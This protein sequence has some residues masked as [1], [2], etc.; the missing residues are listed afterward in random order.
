MADGSEVTG[1]PVKLDCKPSNETIVE[2]SG[3]GG[4]E[5]TG[6]NAAAT[7][8]ERD[9]EL[10]ISDELM[11]KGDEAAA[12]KD[13][14]EATDCYSRALEIRATLFGEL[15]PR[16]VNAYYKYGC[17]LLRKAQEEAD[18]LVSVP[19]RKGDSLLNSC[20]DEPAKRVVSAES[21]AA[22]VESSNGEGEASVHNEKEINN[23]SK[24]KDIEENEEE[25]ESEDE[26]TSEGDEDESDL[27]LAW[28]ML[29]I[30]RAIV[31]KCSEDTM[32]KVDILTAL[33]EVA[34]EREDMETSCSDYLKALSILERLVEPDSR[35]VCELNFM[36][37]LCLETGSK[38][39]EAISYCE[40]AISVCKSRLERLAEEVKTSL[41]PTESSS[42]LS[43]TKSSTIPHSTD[44][45]DKEIE[46]LTD[47]CSELEKKRE[48]L[49]HAVANP[50]PVLQDILAMY[51]AKTKGSDKIS[52]SVAMDPSQVATV[53]SGG[54]LDS[55]TVSTAHT[56]GSSR[57]TDLGVVGRGVKRVHLDSIASETKPE[58]KPS[59]DP[60]N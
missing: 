36:I 59:L 24:L 7:S 22:S 8:A 51:S 14:S 10:K 9:D 57:V 37:C 43:V 54:G 50:T 26:D 44:N 35:R 23:D 41:V 53:N 21:S 16:C 11:V 12:G 33:A 32:E 2:L 45:T 29:D 48:E 47:L 15:D 39:E 19:K 46:T 25:D 52:T 34:L 1:P 18:P 28:K 49:K 40:K 56:N 38:P 42:D 20:K 55:P 3:Q 6:N 31:E 60:P 27:D 4:T 58:K 5:S 17:A 13:Y 30:A